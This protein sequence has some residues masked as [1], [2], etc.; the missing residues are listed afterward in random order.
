LFISAKHSACAHETSGCHRLGIFDRPPNALIR[1]GLAAVAI[2]ALLVMVS[3][4]PDHDARP[5]RDQVHATLS[6]AA[7]THVTQA[8]PLA[9]F[10]SLT[11]TV[12]ATLLFLGSVLIPRADSRRTSVSPIRRRGPPRPHR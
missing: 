11:A 9:G 4:V 5:T 10:L 2:G 6:V 12:L 8:A 7:R 3:R 1:R